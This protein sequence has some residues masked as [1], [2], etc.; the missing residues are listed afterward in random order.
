MTV[1]L[2]RSPC[3]G[4]GRLPRLTYET[5]DTAWH[6]LRYYL[7]PSVLGQDISTA[8][9]VTKQ[10]KRVRGH[11]MAK[12][13]LENAVWDLLAQATGK[14]LCEVLGG[15]RTRVEVGGGEYRDSADFRRLVS[16]SR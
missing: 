8:A 14:P 16:A 15:V 13:A 10:F 1:G 12:T 11:P 5:V 6:V 2:C 3:Q 4:P 7:I 9:D